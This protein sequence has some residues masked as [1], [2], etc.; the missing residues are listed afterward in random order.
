MGIWIWKFWSIWAVES[1]SGYPW[2]S[3]K[4]NWNLSSPIHVV[5]LL[6]LSLPALMFSKKL[7]PADCG[8]TSLHPTL[9]FTI[10]SP[11]FCC[12][13][14][15]E[16]VCH[17]TEVLTYGVHVGPHTRNGL[18]CSAHH[19]TDEGKT[20]EL[21]R[22]K[23]VAVPVFKTWR[24]WFVLFFWFSQYV[25]YVPIPWIKFTGSLSHLPNY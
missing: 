4:V 22:S 25:K 2:L 13:R 7:F 12:N 11:F 8:F 16:W 14:Q 24:D 9:Y 19:I 20:G 18:W 3:W 10:T 23:G 5:Y 21:E 17:I 6:Q 1:Y 15:S